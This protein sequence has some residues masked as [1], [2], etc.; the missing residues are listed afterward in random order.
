[1]NPNAL[2]KKNIKKIGR[3][4]DMISDLAEYFKSIEFGQLNQYKKMGMLPIFTNKK[5]DIQYFTLTEALKANAIDITEIDE[6]GAVSE[7]KVKNRSE[8]P[9]LILDG[10][11]LIGAKQNRI[12]NTSILL[13]ENCETI[14]PVSC[15]EQGRWNYVSKE[16]QN[17]DRL[18]SH[19]IRNVKTVSVNKSVE[20]SG[21]FNSDQLAVWNEINKLENRTEVHSPTSAMGDIYDTFTEDLENYVKKFEITDGQRG[22]LVFI[23]GEI[24]GL[25][26]VSNESAYRILHEKL[27]KS[28][29]MDSISQKDDAKMKLEMN[30][31][32]VNKFIDEI[33]R[34]SEYK[35]KSVGYGF[36]HRFA[37][38]SYTGSVVV[39]KKEVI[40]ASFFKN[41]EIME[42]NM[43][44]K[45]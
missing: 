41:P 14:I 44:D 32:G 2:N 17:S 39:F 21:N 42:D 25:D 34:S 9:V 36:D 19:K 33:V 29:A 40:H 15:V 8:I 6:K 22:L 43:R 20:N 28:Y 35:S 13:K 24:R 38:D 31:E 4:I 10:E 12:V 45:V 3:K 23:N 7:L 27:I 11:E 26:V 18:A 37:S 1:M 16:F 30:I 5:S